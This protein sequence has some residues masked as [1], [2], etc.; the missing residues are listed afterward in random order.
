LR[1]PVASNG[2]SRQAVEDEECGQRPP[3]LHAPDDVIDREPLV[4]NETVFARSRL[5]HVRR[6]QNIVR[7]E[8]HA[9]AGEEEEHRVAR[10]DQR[11]QVCEL[12]VHFTPRD[13]LAGD[14]RKAE[15]AKGG[16]DGPRVAHRSREPWLVLVGIDADDKREALRRG[17]VG[18][19]TP[20]ADEGGEEAAGQ[21]SHFQR[22]RS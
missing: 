20:T 14:D 22:P 7:A 1:V 8:R 12:A 16:S 10:T 17:R 6:K 19:Q 13:V 15:F 11:F 21:P 18:Q 3:A 5:R 4:A 2:L 9:M